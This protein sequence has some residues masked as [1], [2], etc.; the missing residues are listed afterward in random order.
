MAEVAQR[1]LQVGATFGNQVVSQAVRPYAGEAG[2]RVPVRTILPAR[3]RGGLFR[4]LEPP[5]SRLPGAAVA[6]IIASSRVLSGDS[7]RRSSSA[8]AGSIGG[9]GGPSPETNRLRPVFFAMFTTR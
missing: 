9:C 8:R 2:R 6:V 7:S 3:S 4:N 1:V 5:G